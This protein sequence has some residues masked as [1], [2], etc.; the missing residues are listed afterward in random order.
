M[1]FRG[2]ER[3]VGFAQH[4]EHGGLRLGSVQIVV[5]GGLHL[6]DGF[7]RQL[8]HRRGR[9]GGKLRARQAEAEVAQFLHRTCRG[10]QAI[11]SEIQLIA[12]GHLRQQPADR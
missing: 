11:E 8:R 10:L 1:N 7:V 2:I 12:I 9:A 6:G 5:E 3:G 4:V